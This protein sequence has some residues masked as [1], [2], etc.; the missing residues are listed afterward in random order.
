MFDVQKF[1]ATMLLEKVK[2]K[3]KFGNRLG[4]GKRSICSKSERPR[5]ISYPYN[6]VKRGWV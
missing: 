3:N 4:S 6:S 2:A 5:G 1:L